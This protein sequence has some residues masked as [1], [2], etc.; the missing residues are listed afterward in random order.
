M[1]SATRHLSAPAATHAPWLARDEAARGTQPGARCHR[2][3]AAD[4]TYLDRLAR[5]ED[6]RDPRLELEWL[7]REH[8]QHVA[9]VRA[10]RAAR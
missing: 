10:G 7:R 6:T 3:V 4:V 1:L 2:R 5:G 9:H 8:E